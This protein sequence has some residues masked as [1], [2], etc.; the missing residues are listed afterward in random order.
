MVA[1]T[2]AVRASLV[3]SQARENRKVAANGF[4]FLE[5]RRQLE[6]GPFLLRGPLAHMRAV[7]NVAERHSPRSG[8]FASRSFRGT[9]ETVRQH[10]VK[11]RQRNCRAD[12]AQKRSPL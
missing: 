3:A 10:R 9:D 1:G 4:E 11:H 2:I 6:I 5:N 7:W 12:A 8:T